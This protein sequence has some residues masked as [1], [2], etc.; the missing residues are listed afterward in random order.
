[1]ILL[2]GGNRSKKVSMLCQVNEPGGF[3]AFLGDAYSGKSNPPYFFDQL[4][5]S[6]AKDPD[7][8]FF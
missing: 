2:N 4:K 7:I 6:Q 8:C 1:M 3:I 5:G